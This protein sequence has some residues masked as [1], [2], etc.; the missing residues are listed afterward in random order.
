MVIYIRAIIVYFYVNESCKTWTGTFWT[1]A[2]SA[3]PGS[4]LHCMLKLQEVKA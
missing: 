4:G 2:D 1:L 3:D